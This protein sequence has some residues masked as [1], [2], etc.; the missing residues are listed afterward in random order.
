MDFILNEAAEV[1]GD[2]FKL[3]FSDDEK[4]MFS[5]TTA[6]DRQFIDD[7]SERQKTAASTE[8]SAT[9]NIIR[10]LS[11][12]HVIQWRSLTSQQKSFMARTTC[13][14][15]TTRKKGEIMILIYLILT[16]IELCA[17]KIV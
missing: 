14:R 8:T 4:E 1:E 16:T 6:D 10:V 3:V 12:R 13:R 15:C 7:S 9:E 2:N 17:L 5:L 11:I